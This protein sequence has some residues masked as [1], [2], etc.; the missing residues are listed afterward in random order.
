MS[1]ES[2]PNQSSKPSP[3]STAGVKTSLVNTPAT[4]ESGALADTSAEHTPQGVNVDKGGSKSSPNGV[5]LMD[6]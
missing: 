6:I 5:G 3:K 1:D 2:K 4:I